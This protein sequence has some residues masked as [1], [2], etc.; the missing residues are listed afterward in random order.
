MHAKIKNAAADIPTSLR[1][2]TN[3]WNQSRI[4]LSFE[5]SPLLKISFSPCPLVKV[6]KATILLKT[7]HRNPKPEKLA[8]AILSWP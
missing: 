7:M 2:F 8:T 3:F 5:G 4:V 6:G 1:I